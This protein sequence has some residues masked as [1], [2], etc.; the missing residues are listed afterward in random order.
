MLITED[1]YNEEMTRWENRLVKTCSICNGVGSISK[2]DSSGLNIMCNCVKRAHLNTRLVAW[3]VPRKYVSNN[4]IWDECTP[5]P[6][7]DE[8]KNYADNFINNYFQGKGLYLFGAQGR[9]KSTMEA[10]IA[11][12]V[13]NKINP[14]TRKPFI[15]AFNIYEDIVQL[16]RQINNDRTA[17][18]KLNK[19]INEPHLL[20]IDNIG[21]EVGFGSDTGYTTKLLEYVLRT[22][23]NLCV[24]TIISSNLTPEELYDAYSDTV[25]DFIEENYKLISVTGSNHRKKV[26][27]NDLISDFESG[28]WL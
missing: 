20:I 4:W 12:E 21:S 9:G 11:R 3:G 19:L 22:R 7:V 28:E 26:K 25:G 15:V 16:K 13:G 18:Y 5:E 23:D 17:L 1:Q 24:P 14:D 2:D 8:C 27:T 6:F 10:L